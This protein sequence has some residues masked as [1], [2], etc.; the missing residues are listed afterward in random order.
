MSVWFDCVLFQF[1]C[2]GLIWEAKLINCVSLS[3]HRSTSV[4]VNTQRWYWQDRC[5]K[6]SQRWV[7]TS[8]VWNTAVQMWLWWSWKLRLYQVIANYSLASIASTVQQTS[9][10][11]MT[12]LTWWVFAM[13]TALVKHGNGL[14]FL[15]F[16]INHNI[17]PSKKSIHCHCL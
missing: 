3:L 2:G 10:L 4:T 14:F 1:P 8:A 9:I 13:F 12:I 16:Y 15:F 5:I 6:K 17:G 7:K 11:K